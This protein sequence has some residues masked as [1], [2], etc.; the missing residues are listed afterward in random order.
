MSNVP[1]LWVAAQGSS[2]LGEDHEAIDLLR[3]SGAVAQRYGTA[4]SVWRLT[5]HG[6]KLELRRSF[7]GLLAMALR[8]GIKSDPIHVV[9]AVLMW[10]MVGPSDRP[11]TELTGNERDLLEALL[12]EQRQA[13]SAIRRKLV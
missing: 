13:S 12:Q 6:D 2:D 10:L 7:D 4:L 9:S 3:A 8:L 5:E 1:E 11:T